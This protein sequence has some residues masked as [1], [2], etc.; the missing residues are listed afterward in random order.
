MRKLIKNV[1]FLKA[2][3]FLAIA[4]VVWFIGEGIAI[5]SLRPLESATARLVVIGLIALVW[6]TW[7]IVRVA[8][9]R[10]ANRKLL[11]GIAG[12]DT[13]PAA[14]QS[15]GEVALLRKRFEEAAAVLK[16]TRFKDRSGGAQYLYQLPWYVFIGA[17]GS[18]KTTALINCGLRFP[19]AQ[20][21]SAA[22]IRGVGGTRN[23]DW[24]FTDDAVFL[25]TAGRYTT[26]ESDAKVDSGAWLGF[27][28]L[29]RRFR[30][31][32]PLN[33]AIVTLSISD[34]LSQ[35]EADRRRYALTVRQRIQ[36]LYDKLGARFPVYLMV[37]KT[38]L[39]AGFLEYFGDLGREERAQVWGTTFPF[40]KGGAEAM[41]YG[42]LFT[43]AF[44]DLERRL[45]ARLVDRLQQERDAQRRAMLYTFPQQFSLVRPLISS[46]LETAFSASR[47]DEQIMLRGVYFTS[48]TQEGS[49]IDRV[50]ASLARSFQ[51]E[52]RVLP[53]AAATGKS[54][55]LTRML[56]DVVF[57]EVGLSGLNEKRER[58]L[59]WIVRGA[60]G[61]LGLV[62]MILLA[63]WGISYFS[64]RGIVNDMDARA[65]DLATKVAA[66]PP[67]RH[68]DI[69][70][71]LPVLNELRDLPYVNAAKRSPEKVS[72]G[73]GLFQ[74]DHLGARAES[75]Y[76]AVLRDAFLT[77]FA[78]RLEE[79]LRS[80]PSPDVQYEALK[81]Y[82]MLFD[83]SHLE[84]EAL[85]SWM[86][87]DW[88]T[89]LPRDATGTPRKD[90]ASHM[91]ALLANRPLSLHFQRDD[92][93]V[94]R[95]RRSL[96]SM[97]LPD[98]VYSRI[99]LIG[100]DNTVEPFRI[101]VVT[102]PAGDQVFMRAK[103]DPLSAPFNPLY[104]RN[105]YEKAFKAQIGDIAAAMVAEESWVLGD[106]VGSGASAMTK[107]QV[108]AEARNRYFE[109]Y[110]RE[111]DKLL[112]D[113]QLKPAASMADTQLYARVLGAR[114]SPLRK[115]AVAASQETTLSP[116]ADG[117]DKALAE[118]AVD[119]VTD[120]TKKALGKILGSAKLATA[121]AS[122]AP[123]KMVDDHFA[124]LHDL[125]AAAAPGQPMPIDA[126][127]SMIND[128]YVELST[129]ASAPRPAGTLLPPLQSGS[130]LGAE[131]DRLP[132]PLQGIVKSLVVQSSGQAA[133]ANQQALKKAIGGAAS[134]CDKAITGRY[135]ITRGSRTDATVED[136]AAVFAPGGDLDQFF[137]KNL[138]AMV[139]TSGPAWKPQAGMEASIPVSPAAIRQFQN[140]DTIRRAMFRGSPQPSASADV[141]LI[142]TDVGT[143]SLDYDGEAIKLSAAQPVA[144]VRWPSQKP[145]PVAK[146]YLS[147]A[148]QQV[149]ADG[150][151]ALFRLFDRATR[152][153]G[154][155]ADR[156]R[157][158]YQIDGKN[159]VVE[160][161]GTSI[162]NPFFLR[163]LSS[164]Q[165][166]G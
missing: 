104:T 144:R 19:L 76:L 88:G 91:Q 139:D 39:L 136:F 145:L 138:Q 149:T 5:F 37:T 60:F 9:A 124:A 82:L 65:R 74:G 4:L 45:G 73:F 28:G 155:P 1:W 77:R 93:L 96:A 59:R 98:R 128:F 31:R 153:A 134:F 58:L 71:I 38:D 27:L 57:Q 147:P 78:I 86:Q 133:A 110:I 64:N 142:S 49:P 97:S 11:D 112:A 16:K 119:A 126:T 22:A 51:L 29:I 164:F 26:Q 118:K 140:A 48:G 102:R 35:S 81:T 55:F 151:W 72:E 150:N 68:D 161:R 160:V 12:A 163:E 165:C 129:A 90:L 87:A 123:E 47:Y 95:T 42:K 92:D 121:P 13:D 54:F 148:G 159:V 107:D 53:P 122:T 100:A 32:Q 117:S 69:A 52:R 41:E 94:A 162:F 6:A 8:R 113:V 115:L 23:C 152:D 158:T 111:W 15:A 2:I 106:A 50:L 146:L 10:L 125:T 80:S 83:D 46:F 79:Q 157:L 7:E 166:P 143:V 85:Q 43:G 21:G 66:F 116:A 25:D 103:G 14:A 127:I 3:G 56:K 135:P 24:W 141:M 108:V 30:P 114:D 20:E 40:R 84:P 33:G 137:T 105:G 34:L 61:A 67:P 17:P 89:L 109:D 101:D 75:T 70:A 36:E 63:G 62:A 44:A 131:A 130:K 99:K 156:I 154:G 120:V 132:V 18:G